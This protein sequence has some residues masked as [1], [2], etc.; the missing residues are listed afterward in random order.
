MSTKFDA[1]MAS[2]NKH[3]VLARINVF[4]DSAS[5]DLYVDE[6]DPAGAGSAV[7]ITGPLGQTTMA[8][9]IPVVIASNQ[10]PVPTLMNNAL[11][12]VAFDNI[13]V[14]LAGAT[15]DVYTYKVAAATVATVTINYFDATKAVITTI[16]RT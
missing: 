10:T 16:V 1:Y 6:R 8:A 12:P 4:K 14:N 11:V 13:A 7:S 15:A 9:S 5:T 3:K 2:I